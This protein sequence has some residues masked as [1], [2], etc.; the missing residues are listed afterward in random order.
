[1][2]SVRSRGIVDFAVLVLGSGIGL[3]GL[4]AYS[5]LV[6]IL[7]TVNLSQTAAVSVEKDTGAGTEGSVS[8]ACMEAKNAAA[9]RG[10]G[11]VATLDKFEGDDNF[12]DTCTAAKLV[13]AK[14][15]Y[16]ASSYVCIGKSARISIMPDGRKTYASSPNERQP[17]GS[18]ATVACG[19]DGENNCF[20]A[21]NVYGLDNET[22]Q[23]GFT[24]DHPEV[25]HFSVDSSGVN[26]GPITPADRN[27]IDAA[28]G[29]LPLDEVPRNEANLSVD[30]ENSLKDIARDTDPSTASKGVDTAIFNDVVA[31]TQINA[32]TKSA[33][34][35]LD[36]SR[37]ITIPNSAN[38][39]IREL[40]PST[41]KINTGSTFGSTPVPV[42]Q[43]N[44]MGDGASGGFW[45]SILSRSS[46]WA[47]QWGQNVRSFMGWDTVPTESDPTMTAGMRG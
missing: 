12:R 30:I 44:G 9:R 37:N 11:D 45:E 42:T 33:V 8:E 16:S 47:N 32:D 35:N 20:A 46:N 15:P 24:T 39:G 34:V 10:Y 17:S 18:C 28:F 26:T 29:R 3:V 25:A 36:P 7:P 31:D 21:K 22:V 27:T 1:M 38:N 19:S 5:S 2:N 13:N 40:A 43:I 41:A 23:S 14:Y 4:F 6:S